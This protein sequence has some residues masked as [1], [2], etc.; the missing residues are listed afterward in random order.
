[1]TPEVS[2]GAADERPQCEDCRGSGT[3]GTCNGCGTRHAEAV[4][5]ATKLSTLRAEVERLTAANESLRERL[6]CA[7]IAWDV[8]KT[9]KASDGDHAELYKAMQRNIADASSAR[10][11]GG[12][13]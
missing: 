4:A 13:V 9:S 6:V 3:C 1:M 2:H 7:Q 8:F 5:D 12:G 11:E 10:R